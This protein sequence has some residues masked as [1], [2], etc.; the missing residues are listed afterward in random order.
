M[1]RT[2][3]LITLIGLSMTSGCI[4]KQDEMVDSF[5]QL[6]TKRHSG[7]S[8]DNS[9]LVTQEQIKAL[10]KA[11]QAAPSSYNDQ[12]WFFIICDRST[13][14]EAYNKVMSTLV[15]FNQQWAQNASVLIVVAAG[16]NSHK[17]QANRWAQ[18]D[19]G[20][21]AMS[22]VL[23]ATSLGL[24]AHQMGGFDETKIS[25]LFGLPADVIPMSVMAVGYENSS[26][27]KSAPKE[28]KPLQDNFFA[29]A[30]GKGV[31]F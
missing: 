23:Q 27:T 29:G 7:Y 15:E 6:M 17:G 21:A 31:N 2:K 16:L 30:W 26:E 24:M 10:V 25:A 4:S 12:P 11:G 14:P 20:A 18:Y 28:R 9:R 1:N 19:S 3:A 13:N 5:T 22:M 8:F